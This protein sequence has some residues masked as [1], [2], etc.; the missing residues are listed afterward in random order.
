MKKV[1]VN[2]LGYLAGPSV[3][4][5]NIQIEVTDEIAEKISSW[6]LG[7]LWC[8]NKEIDD[9]ELVTSYDMSDFRLLRENECFTVINRSFMWYLGLTDEQKNELQEWY[10]AWL[11]ITE[12]REI[13]KKPTWLK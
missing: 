3:T 8:Y 5:A 7:K 1:Y 10:Q 13:P 11:D 4:E 6:P 12:T 9:F 2:N